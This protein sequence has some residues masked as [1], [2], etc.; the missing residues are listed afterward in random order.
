MG[1]KGLGQ[2]FQIIG[3]YKVDHE[4]FVIMPASLLFFVRIYASGA[5]LSFKMI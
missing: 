1:P 5:S 4:T 2:F 3:I